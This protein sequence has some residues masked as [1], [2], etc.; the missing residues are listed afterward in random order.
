MAAQNNYNSAKYDIALKNLDEIDSLNLGPPIPSAQLLRVKT[1]IALGQ[2]EQAETALNILYSLELPSDVLRE[3][4]P[5]QEKVDDWIDKRDKKLAAERL[6]AERKPLIERAYI[7]AEARGRRINVVSSTGIASSADERKESDALRQF[8]LLADG[9][10]ISLST[11]AK[12]GKATAPVL[13]RYT[14]TR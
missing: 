6:W 8:H 4:A 14:K 2:W 3:A 10:H 12:N 13:A 1:H 11:R 7:E 5:L 9:G